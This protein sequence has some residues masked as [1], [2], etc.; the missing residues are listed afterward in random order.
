MAQAEVEA[1]VER[2]IERAASEACYSPVV[3]AKLFAESPMT[4]RVIAPT[5]SLRIEQ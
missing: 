1:V 4:S 3:S 5:G 2:G